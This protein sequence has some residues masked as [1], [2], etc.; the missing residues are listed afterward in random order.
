M[1]KYTSVIYNHYA[2]LAK[3]FA[4]PRRLELL[5]LLAQA[6]RSVESLSQ[7]SGMSVANT[8]QHLQQLRQAKLVSSDKKG[9]QVIYSLSS[10]QVHQFLQ[11]LADLAQSQMAEIQQLDITFQQEW[12]SWQ[13]L[14]W[15]E[16]QSHLEQG[17]VLVDVRPPEEF[18]SGHI[19]G[20]ISIPLKELEKRWEELPSKQSIIAY[21]RG[22]YCLFA[23]EALQILS[24]KYTKLLHY[25]DGYSGYLQVVAS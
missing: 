11:N 15:S 14:N 6:P 8:S 21:C 19:P 20:S 16:L 23:P 13:N 7:A 1:N 4:A 24:Q 3:M 10:P 25:R 9:L 2:S 22:P 17:A 5:E 18:D 12:H